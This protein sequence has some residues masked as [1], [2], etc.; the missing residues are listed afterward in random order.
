MRFF[1]A[2]TVTAP[3]SI[4]ATAPGSVVRRQYSEH[5]MSGP[6]DAPKPAQA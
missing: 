2:T 3:V 5:S 6:K 4:P 1:Q